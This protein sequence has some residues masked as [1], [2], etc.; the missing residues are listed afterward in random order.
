VK[1]I[2]K[3]GVGTHGLLN[4]DIKQLTYITERDIIGKPI[5]GKNRKKA[6]RK[7]AVKY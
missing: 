1:E 6:T 4:P 3:T 2:F 7:K 5:A